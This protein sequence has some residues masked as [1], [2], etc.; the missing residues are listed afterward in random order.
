[1]LRFVV[2]PCVIESEEILDEVAKVVAGL[3]RKYP[4]YDF[5]FKSS[6]DK[7][8]RT[9]LNSY[10]GP[11]LE[12]GLAM[13]KEIKDRYNLKLLTDVHE[14]SQVQSLARVVDCIQIPAFL[15]RQTDLIV[16][17]AKSGVS[18][19]IKKGQFMSGA[20]MLYSYKKAIDSGCKDVWLTERGNS[21]GYNNLVVDF[22]NLA[23]M[24]KITRD[25]VMD[26]THSVQR[27][28]QGGITS[29]NREFV[30]SMALSALMWGVT[31]FFIETHPNPDS[32][33]SDAANMLK[34]S[35][36]EQLID[37]LHAHSEI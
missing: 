2:G 33:K 31:S 22:R 37:K 7:A 20:D 6:F 9:A 17:S 12:K 26:C 29:G 34:L 8:N 11:G 35:D 32:A 24:K 28:S 10:R 30:P 16:E 19:N 27:P 36:L 15:C 21:F 5:Y 1:M 18:V 13:L 25:V 23:D 3:S 4:M 14:T